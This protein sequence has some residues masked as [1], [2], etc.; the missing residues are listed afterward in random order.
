MAEKKRLPY[1]MWSSP[2]SP[3]A[4]A[5]RTRLSDVAW[6]TDGDTL[7]WLEGRSDRGVLVCSQGGSAPRDLTESH[8][9]RARVGYGGG[10]F[11]VGHGHVIYAN[12]ADGRL[13][14]QAL[15]HGQPSPITP[16]FGSFASPTF[17]PTGEHLLCVHSYE[18]RDALVLLDAEGQQWPTKIKQ[19]ADFYM[20]PCW[21]PSG[22]TIAWIEWDHP[23]MPWDETRL[24][25]AEV[26][27]SSGTLKDITQRAGG[28]GLTIL[29]PAFSPDGQ[30]L[31]YIT[32]HNDL[33]S[34]V[35]LS[36]ETGNTTH[37]ASDTILASP[38]WA[39]GIRTYGWEP[40]SKGLFYRTNDK[41][42]ARL[43]Q[44]RLE[45]KQA[46]PL[47]QAAYTWFDQVTVSPT[48]SEVAFF[49]SSSAISQRLL[50]WVD[51]STTIVCRSTAE[52]V[53]P[54]FYAS[55]KPIQWT[56]TD[57]TTVHGIYHPPTN[58][59]AWDDGLPPAIIQIHGGPTAQSVMSFSPETAFYTS[60]GF[61]VLAVNY[62]GS[63]GYGKSYTDALKGNWGILDVEDAELG[64]KALVD[65]RL[66]DPNR[67]VIQGGS[68]GGYTV[69]QALTT[70]PG[71]FKAG[72]SLFGVGNLFTLGTGTHKFESRYLDSLIGELP[73][74]TAIYRERSPLFH[75]HQIKDPV[76]IFQ[77]S[78]D[79]V[80]PPDQAESIVAALKSNGTP[81]EYHLYEGEGHGWR[82]TETIEAYY[83]SVLRFLQQYVLFG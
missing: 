58:P 55:P 42:R 59:T 7:V 30:Y 46:R 43:W 83:N 24:Y 23:N 56:S 27:L 25:T 2:V 64:A 72:I 19:G 16:G 50:R 48:R 75:A 60:R 17:S 53:A 45:D 12:A 35:L 54:A 68:A 78:E 63:T 69:L 36:L 3:S 29:Q 47:D 52:N 34:L 37:L 11:T 18:D 77:G 70:R 71:V 13:Y 76:A 38:A 67:L 74:D 28:E 14:R 33:E 62:R 49:A 8:S 82:K 22:D 79:R 39:Q 1:G 73:Q 61:A 21:H 65:Q 20:S 5:K 6:D 32:T 26:H 66:V 31:S 51:Y 4:L 44:I 57:G 15:E 41:G 81:H 40:D 10:D 9:V 80:V